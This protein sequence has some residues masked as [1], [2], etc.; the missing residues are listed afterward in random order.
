[1]PSNFIIRTQVRKKGRKIKEK[2]K[3]VVGPKGLGAREAVLSFKDQ[4]LLNVSRTKNN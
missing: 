2:R 1:V 4:A 3:E